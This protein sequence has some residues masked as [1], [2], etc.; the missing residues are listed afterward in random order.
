MFN[1]RKDVFKKIL[2]TIFLIVI[3]KLLG[4]ILIPGVSSSLRGL[5]DQSSFLKVLN[6]FS[7][8]N[9]EQCSVMCLHIMPY[10]TSSILTQILSSKTALGVEYFQKLKQDKEMGN[11]RLNEW[12]QYFTIFI[13]FTKAYTVLNNIYY[14]KPNGTESIF[15]GTKLFF[16]LG[17]TTVVGFSMF[18]IWIANQISKRGFGNGISVIIFINILNSLINTINNT[19]H[20]YKEGVIS[21]GILISVIGFFIAISL[22]VIFVENITKRIPVVFLGIQENDNSYLPLKINNA[23]VTPTIL[24]STFVSFP[25]TI[26][27]GLSN[28]GFKF[29][30]IQKYIMYFSYGNFLYYIFLAFLLFVFTITHTQIS[31]DLE[32]VTYNLQSSK[33]LLVDKRPGSETIRYLKSIM[34]NLNL[35]AAVYLITITI[36]TELFCQYINKT[37]GHPFLAFGGTTVLILMGVAQT[38]FKEIVDYDYSGPLNKLKIQGAK[39]EK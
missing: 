37:V 7:G 20:L 25:Q 38:M 21:T 36:S 12:T 2:F 24:A 3:Y 5:A 22:L 27:M 32:D 6:M 8:G 4:L 18:S 9:L 17:F 11:I 30:S 10:L 29:E 13:T 31:F 26:C 39:N 35:I 1:H 28:L 14:Y 34:S 16:L 23:G 33:I 15:I 19:A